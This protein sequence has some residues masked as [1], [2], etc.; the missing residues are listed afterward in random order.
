M[1]P[2]PCPGLYGIH[3]ITQ[4]GQILSSTLSLRIIMFSFPLYAQCIFGQGTRSVIATQTLRVQRVH[5]LGEACIPE[6]QTL[7]IVQCMN[8]RSVEYL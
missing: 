4:V 7:N 5:L 1:A 2:G 8:R 6:W 3:K